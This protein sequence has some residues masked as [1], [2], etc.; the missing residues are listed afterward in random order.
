[1]AVTFPVAT[2]SYF[3]ATNKASQKRAFLAASNG[4][5]TFAYPARFSE[6]QLQEWS[7]AVATDEVLSH[8]LAFLASA[9]RLQTDDSELTAFRQFNVELFGEPHK[10]FAAS[11]LARHSA[12]IRPEDEML[13]KEVQ[14]ILG[15]DLGQTSQVGPDEQ[16]FQRCRSYLRRYATIPK[17]GEDVVQAL[18]SQLDQIGLTQKGWRLRILKGDEHA[19]TYHAAK[20]ISVGQHYQPR[21][22]SA[23]RRIVLHEVLG[24]AVRGP[25][26]TLSESEG[27]AIVIE[28]LTQPRFTMRR[29]YRYLAA[30]VGWGVFGRPMTFR[31]THEVMWRMMVIGSDYSEVLAKGHAFDECY[32]VFRGGRPDLAG[33]VFL[34]DTVY[35]DGNM[36]IWGVLKH[37]QL[38][39]NEFID[40]IE[41][42]RILLS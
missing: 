31:A 25:Q 39:Y 4:N 19:H 33:A 21:T 37:E 16:T 14:T 40:C 24:H 1:M 28:Q 30:S 13:W 38:E 42:R 6:A 29:S 5:P 11:I 17:K 9:A 3:K 8:R 20:T 10:D 27:F 23:V 12:S 18:Q 41:G 7:P 36:R 34:K 22:L 32:R 2:H 15:V 26:K 35:F